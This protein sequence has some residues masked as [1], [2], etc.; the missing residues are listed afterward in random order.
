MASN[1]A[2]IEDLK[3]QLDGALADLE[4]L[5]GQIVTANEELRILYTLGTDAN[6]AVAFAKENLNAAIK[7]FKHEQQ[8]VSEATLNIEK[9]RAE[10]ALARLAL[11]EVIAKYSDALPYSIVPNGNG[12]TFAGTPFGNNPSGSPLGPVATGGS[13]ANGAFLIKDWTHYLSNAFGAGI[14]P[15][16][17]G[18]VNELYPFNFLSHVDGNIVKNSYNLRGGCGGSGPL[19]AITGAVVA[20]R[21]DSF[22]V[23]LNDGSRYT[24]NI[25][26]CTRL[27]ANV[28]NYHLSLGDQAVVK[29]NLKSANYI[30]GT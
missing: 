13:G 4:F 29:G 26:P 28:D 19:K 2:L 12:Q 30:S 9:A 6:T 23:E 7:R 3:A 27:S 18:S 14:H 10:E 21:D 17:P 20:I 15:A 16:Y 11:E 8:I 5:N 1:A 25:N 22:D 24:I